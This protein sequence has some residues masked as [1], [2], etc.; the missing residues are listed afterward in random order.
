MVK[1][2][3]VGDEV[4]MIAIRAQGSGGQH[5][6]KVSTAIHLR[7]DIRASSLAEEDKIRLLQFKDHRINSDGVVVIKAQQFRSQM[8]NKEDALCRLDALIKAGT[9]VQK[10]RKVAKRSKGSIQKRLANK[11]QR[12]QLKKLRKNDWNE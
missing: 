1:E 8:K 11:N 10:K 2:I 3:V 6:N 9:V 7:F 5:V 4:Q 12:S